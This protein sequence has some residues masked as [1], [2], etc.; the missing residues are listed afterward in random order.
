MLYYLIF[1]FPVPRAA[2]QAGWGASAAAAD[3]AAAMRPALCA[4]GSGAPAWRIGRASLSLFVAE[5]RTNRIRVHWL[6]GQCRL[7][8]RSE[9][10]ALRC[11]CVGVIGLIGEWVHDAL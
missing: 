7:R 11:L 9:V 4:G 3:A 8:R 2:S 6:W 1:D 5:G 10:V